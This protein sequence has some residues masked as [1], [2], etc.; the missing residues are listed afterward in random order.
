MIQEGVGFLLDLRRETLTKNQMNG[1][2]RCV[3]EFVFRRFGTSPSRVQKEEVAKAVIGLF[4]NIKMVRNRSMNFRFLNYQ[5][6]LSD[7]KFSQETLLNSNDG[8]KLS[9]QLR[10]KRFLAKKGA[11]KND[12]AVRSSLNGDE[13]KNAVEVLKSMLVN[14]TN[15]DK[16][17]Q[18]LSSTLEYRRAKLESEEELN[19]QEYFPYFF[20]SSE[21]VMFSTSQFN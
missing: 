1:L 15:M 14:E 9:I 2:M 21:L 17:K 7:R 19:L 12:V 5:L 13:A 3:G 4:P 6:T 11:Q 10:N 8:G 16:F 18:L 20:V